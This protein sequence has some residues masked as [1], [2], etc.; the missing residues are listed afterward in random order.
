MSFW[1]NRRKSQAQFATI[2]DAAEAGDLAA[3]QAFVRGEKNPDVQA[4]SGA[5]ALH[6]ASARGYLDVVKLLVESGSEIDFLIEEGGTPLMA[7]AAGLRPLIV[8]FLL[9]KGAQP[10]KKGHDGRFPL[11]CAFQPA[12]IA[13]SD[14]VKTIRLLV[15]YGADVNV[16]TDSG[17]TPL[18]NAAWFG[19]REAAEELL[20]LGA[21]A[22]LKN[23]NGKTAATLA[24]ER[25]HDSLAQ[26]LARP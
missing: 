23:A 25:G 1:N 3:V 17:I 6:I 5:T 10:N 26:L 20:R 9:T 12:V 13:V 22:T 2:H 7:A 11:V 8:E 4:P 14:Q 21:E 16:C 19:N 15:E 24:F 18:M